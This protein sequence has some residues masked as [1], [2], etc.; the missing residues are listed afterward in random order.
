M[1]GMDK[2]VVFI[3]GPDRPGIIAAVAQTLFEQGCNLEDISQT[4]LQGQFVGI[5]IV[6]PDGG[7]CGE[8]LPGILRERLSPWGCSCTCGPSRPW[9]GG[10][11]RRA[12]PM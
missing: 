11:R 5:F 8:A 4:S 1:T 3:L 10:L 12:S 7:S 6:S 9:E 2:T